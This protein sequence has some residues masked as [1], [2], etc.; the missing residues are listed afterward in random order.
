MKKIRAIFNLTLKWKFCPVEQVKRG[1]R[2]AFTKF[3]QIPHLY[4]MNA[5][6]FHEILG[7]I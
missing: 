6:T 4:F 1:T 7:L 3:L 2:E 5:S